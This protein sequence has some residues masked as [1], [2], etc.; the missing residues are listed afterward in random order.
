MLHTGRRHVEGGTLPKGV[1]GWK[2]RLT[3]DP[4]PFALIALRKPNPSLHPKQ[5]GGCAR[6]SQWLEEGAPGAGLDPRI[7]R[8]TLEA[9]Q[10]P[11]SQS[12]RQVRS[13]TGCTE[14]RGRLSPGSRLAMP[15]P[16]SPGSP[17]G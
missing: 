5:N 6:Q 11:E 9:A 3:A 8:E 15:A 17:A 12:R 1:G 10:H 2:L 4:D 13:T 14:G 16:G 7:A